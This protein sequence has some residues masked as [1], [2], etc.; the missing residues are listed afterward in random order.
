MLQTAQQEYGVLEY[1]ALL[2]VDEKRSA[3]RQIKT[4]HPR[5]SSNAVG[6]LL[7]V[8]PNTVRRW[9]KAQDQKDGGRVAPQSTGDQPMTEKSSSVELNDTVTDRPRREAI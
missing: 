6:A 7:S 1:L 2:S 9:L 4:R 5:I 3:V 8:H